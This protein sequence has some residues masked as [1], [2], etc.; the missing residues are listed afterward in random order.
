MFLDQSSA[1]PSPALVPPFGDPE[2]KLHKN[3]KMHDASF[4]TAPIDFNDDNGNTSEWANLLNREGEE[5]EN[6]RIP[7][8]M[9]KRDTSTNA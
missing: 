8:K 7:P 6:D 3:M 1:R 4:C 2:S 9:V 5:N